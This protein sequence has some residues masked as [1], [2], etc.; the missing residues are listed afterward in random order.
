LYKEIERLC[1]EV[2]IHSAQ[3]QEVSYWTQRLVIM[4]TVGLAA[5]VTYNIKALTK[6]ERVN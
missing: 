3:L 6:P 1:Y 5:V 4:R 2:A